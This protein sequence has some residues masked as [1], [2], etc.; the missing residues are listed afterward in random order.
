MLSICLGVTLN[1]GLESQGFDPPKFLAR[2]LLLE[3]PLNAGP[4]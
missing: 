2:A 3:G 4:L 1:I